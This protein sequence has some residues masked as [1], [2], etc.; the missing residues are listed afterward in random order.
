M[1]RC[2]EARERRLRRNQ[3]CQQFNLRLLFSHRIVRNKC[4][5]FKP[6]YLCY[7]VMLGPEN[8]YK[9]LKAVTLTLLL[10]LGHWQDQLASSHLQLPIPLYHTVS[11]PLSLPPSPSPVPLYPQSSQDSY[12][13]TEGLHS[14]CPMGNQSP[15]VFSNLISEV[16]QIHFSWDVFAKAITKS[17]TDWREGICTCDDEHIVK[18]CADVF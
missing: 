1:W 17:L 9:W 6:P 18:V 11:L 5:W 13:V 2:R 12:M 3:P 4:M 8:K 16:T 14:K 15:M 10:K 7:L